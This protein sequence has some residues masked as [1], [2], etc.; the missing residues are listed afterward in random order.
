M[1]H[2]HKWNILLTIVESHVLFGG[3]SQETPFK[4]QETVTFHCYL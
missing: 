3:E 2:D 4:K 1:I